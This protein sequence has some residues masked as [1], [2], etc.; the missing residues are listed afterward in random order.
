MVITDLSSVSTILPSLEGP[1]GGNH[2]VFQHF[3]WHPSP[4]N[5]H[6]RCLHVFSWPDS[7]CLQ[8]P[9]NI[10][11]YG[12]NTVL[13]IHLFTCWRTSW[14]L[15]KA[16]I[17]ICVQVFK[18]TYIFRFMYFKVQLKYLEETQGGTAWFS[19]AE[20]MPLYCVP[21]VPWDPP[22]MAR[23]RM[24][25]TVCRPTTPGRL[26]ASGLKDSFSS[27]SKSPAL[28]GQN[29]FVHLHLKL[30]FNS[31]SSAQHFLS[32]PLSS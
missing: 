15:H 32:M 6:L 16:A 3:S 5:M 10:L 2:R 28:S 29:I 9:N 13:F 19:R 31:W 21:R 4:N 8:W 25:S 30:G 18:W 17:N 1:I 26:W 12:S 24:Y 23:I 11:L 22:A 20:N 14:L 27:M 7:S